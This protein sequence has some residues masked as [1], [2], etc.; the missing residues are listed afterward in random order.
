LRHKLNDLLVLREQQW[1]MIPEYGQECN[2]E[3]SYQDSADD[4]LFDPVSY[5]TIHAK[6]W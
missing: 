5:P 3:Q 6:R 1:D 4:S 2:I